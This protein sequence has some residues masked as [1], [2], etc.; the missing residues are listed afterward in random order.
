MKV[1]GMSDR[2]Y[3]C[4]VTHLELEKL[5]DKYFGNLDRLNVGSELD[6]GAGY[7]FSERIESACKKMTEANKSFGEAQTTMMKFAVMIAEQKEKSA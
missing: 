1:I 3:I 6:L 4:V 7:N 2:D 5:T